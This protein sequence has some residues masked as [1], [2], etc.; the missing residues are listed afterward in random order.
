MPLAGVA[1]TVP[2]VPT[3]AGVVSASMRSSVCSMSTTRARR[4][5]SVVDMVVVR[6]V[7]GTL[8]A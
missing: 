4:S 8:F 1:P 5:S 2:V 3:G 6:G 7:A